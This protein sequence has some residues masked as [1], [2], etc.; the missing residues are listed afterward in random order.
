M[1]GRERQREKDKENE[2]GNR[3]MIAFELGK[4]GV[5]KKMRRARM[6]AWTLKGATGP[7]DTEG[8]WRPAWALIC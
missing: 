3:R 4:F 8:A 5:G 2:Q 1:E 7:C 6:L